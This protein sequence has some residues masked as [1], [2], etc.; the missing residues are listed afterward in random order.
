M[1][2]QDEAVADDAEV[3]VP[4]VRCSGALHRVFRGE[5]TPWWMCQDEKQTLVPG[6]TAEV[7]YLE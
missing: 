1:T 2:T 3:W 7:R 5:A 4:C 6:Q